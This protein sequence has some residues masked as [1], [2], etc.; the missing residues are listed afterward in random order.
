MSYRSKSE[1]DFSSRIYTSFGSLQEELEKRWNDKELRKKVDDFFHKNS[2]KEFQGEPRAVLSR[3]LSTPNSELLYFLDVARDLGLKPLILEYPDKFVA[4]NP[5]K[6]HLAK[7]FFYKKRQDLNSFPVFTS[8]IIDFNKQEGKKLSDISTLWGE[9]IADFHH[10]L[11]FEVVPQ[12]KGNL[13]DFSSWFD[14]TRFS[15]KF[16]YLNFL[17]LFICNGVLFENFL[18]D[19]KEESG[20]IKDK[21][22]PS[23]DEVERIFGVKPLIFPL[24]PFDGEK[25]PYWLSYSESLQKYLINKLSYNKSNGF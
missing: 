15:S 1:E 5:D 7:L 6:Y 22:L 8:K 16:Y 9:N 23:F 3:A 12:L 17:S 25:H 19:D 21:F 4:K 2:L 13:V 11:L 18:I 10:N 20:F 24:L 14:S